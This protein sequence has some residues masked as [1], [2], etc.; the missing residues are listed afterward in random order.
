MLTTR[1]VNQIEFG[2]CLSKLFSGLFPY[3]SCFDYEERGQMLIKA[4]FSFHS[5]DE[6]RESKSRN[7]VIRHTEIRL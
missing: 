4:A 6:N 1:L 7:L 3:S 2:K 5:Q